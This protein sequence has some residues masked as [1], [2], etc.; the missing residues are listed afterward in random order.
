MIKCLWPQTLLNVMFIYITFNI[1]VKIVEMIY[2]GIL[3]LSMFQLGLLFYSPVDSVGQ[4]CIHPITWSVKSFLAGLIVASFSAIL[5][6]GILDIQAKIGFRSICNLTFVFIF[7]LKHKYEHIFVA[8]LF[9]P[10]HTFYFFKLAVRHH[11]LSTSPLATAAEFQKHR[12]RVLIDHLFL[13]LFCTT[14]V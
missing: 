1:K 3:K 13:H 2:S 11:N 5:S 8:F 10:N 9:K 12:S 14:A 4:I 7:I 6:I